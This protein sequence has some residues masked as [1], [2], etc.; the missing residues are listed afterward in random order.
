MLEAELDRTRRSG[1]RCVVVS[2]E[3]GIGKT[4]LLGEFAHRV[5]LRDG[6]VV[7]YGRCDEALVPLQPF[8]SIVG[9]CVEHA[10]VDVLRA[11]VAAL[12][13]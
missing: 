3:P 10:P 7:V 8:R 4:S 2:G 1:L 6:P 12:R 9:T 5:A 11:H 13:R